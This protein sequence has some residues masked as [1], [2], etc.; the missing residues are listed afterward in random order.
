MFSTI[1]FPPACLLLLFHSPPTITFFSRQGGKSRCAKHLIPMFP[2]AHTYVEVFVGAGN[3]ILRIPKNTF[4]TEIINDLDSTIY[5]IFTDI[6]KVS[7][8]DVKDMDFIANGDRWECVHTT[9]ATEL[10][11]AARLEHNLYH[12][13]F[14]FA[15]GM[16]SYYASPRSTTTSRKTTLMDRLPAIQERLSGVVV[17]NESYEDIIKEYDGEDVFFYLDPPY[18][19]SDAS[20]YKHKTIDH[21]SLRDLLTN[22]KGK[23]LISYN[24]HPFIRE[25]YKDFTIKTIKTFYTIK[26]AEVEE[27]VI[28][29]Y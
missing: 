5:Q 16:S 6:Q 1:F 23:W 24:D 22:T 28:T 12:I 18:Y 8:D 20:G 13:Y 27:L 9:D 21:V 26:R 15:G 2:H 25:L 3:V 4:A 7:L 10:P 11:P 19:Q 17:R 14:S 29:N